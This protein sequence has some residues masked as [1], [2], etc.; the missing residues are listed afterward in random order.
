MPSK[1]TLTITKGC[2]AGRKYVF[3]GHE[4]VIVGRH[5]DCGIVLSQKTVSRYHCMLEITPPFIAIRDFG[6]LNGTYLN[7]RLIGRWFWNANKFD[8][9]KQR[10]HEF[11][12]KTGDVLGI[13]PGCEIMVKLEP[14]VYPQ[15]D[16]GMEPQASA[17]ADF[18]LVTTF[19][20]NTPE[21]AAYNVRRCVVCGADLDNTRLKAKLCFTC[22]GDHR[23][24]IKHLMRQSQK[25]DAAKAVKQIAGCKIIKMLGS[26]STSEVWLAKEESTGRKMAL[27]LMLPEMTVVNAKKANF[28]REAWLCGQLRHKNIVRQFDCG[29][30]DEVF[31]ILQELCDGGNVEDLAANYGGALNINLATHIILQVLN[32]L[33]YAHTAALK[34]KLNCG[35]VVAAKGLVHR[36]LKPAN[37]FLTGDMKKPL[38]KVADFGL[39]KAFEKNGLAGNTRTGQSS[40]TPVFM[41]MQQIFD[42]K[43]ALPEVD[44]WAA[45]ACYYFMLT[46]TYPKDFS[47]KTYDPWY[48]ALET[49]AIPIRE[50]NDKVPKKL[51]AV[52]DKALEEMPR[53]G[54]RSAMELKERIK[55][56]FK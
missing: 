35:N 19:F 4:T 40:G 55:G 31:F 25:K 48:V 11:A 22:K 43:L 8:G 16:A 29:C 18:K 21:R 12:V 15:N 39:A 1:V 24:V 38:V 9:Q 41:P 49:A 44:V 56:A 34:V 2:D 3:Y 42:Y 5:V 28:M 36:D 53:I 20:A 27:K 14:C 33:E 10:K 51:A 6:S 13:G 23:R 45:A 30:E 26:G 50:R 7:G 52:I 32:G 37:I 17:N 54:I 47:D 46:G